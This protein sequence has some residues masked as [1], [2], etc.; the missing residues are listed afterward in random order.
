MNTLTPPVLN[1]PKSAPV[2]LPLRTALILGG[3]MLLAILAAE[4]LRPTR[5]L[6]DT[7][8]LIKLETQ[9][10]SHF[11][12][13]REDKSLVP[14]LPNPELQAQ[15]DTL[16]SQLLA[17]TYINSR[18]E[19]IMLAIAYGSD[20]SSEATA[21]HRPEFCYSAQGFRVRSA[22]L[23]TLTFGGHD[24]HVQRLVAAMAP[25]IEPITYWV[26]LDNVAT[27]P[28]LGRK[29]QQISYG[30]QGNIPDGML[31]RVS[32]IG[33]D[34]AAGFSI[35]EDFLKQMRAALPADVAARYFGF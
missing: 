28:G 20:Q 21:V 32:N 26:T 23:A 9:V 18:G 15:L 19:R 6:A 30:L 10:P 14:V 13:W 25:R 35:Q 2:E 7:Q 29:L 3:L 12:D 33:A 5:H 1:S 31:V 22:G 34:E 8:A 24:L 17:R 27:L 16:Y 11:G 4:W